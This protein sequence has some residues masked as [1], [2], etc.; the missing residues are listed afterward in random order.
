MVQVMVNEKFRENVPAWNAFSQQAEKFPAFFGRVLALV[1]GGSGD[2]SQPALKQTHERVTFL[3]FIIHVFQS[4]EQ[5]A[6]RSQALKLVS[7][8]L[9]HALSRG[10]LQVLDSAFTM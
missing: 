3:L 2:G 4:L 6:V 7:L 1:G 5:E 10:R 8:P 9:W